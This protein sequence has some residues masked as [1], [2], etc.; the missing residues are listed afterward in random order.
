MMSAFS[1]LA[2]WHIEAATVR[3]TFQ[4]TSLVRSM[5]LQRRSHLMRESSSGEDARTL[6]KWCSSQQDPEW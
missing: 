5:Y 2:T 6:D 4:L 1:A 3:R